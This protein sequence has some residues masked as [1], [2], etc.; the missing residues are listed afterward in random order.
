MASE[1]SEHLSDDD[2][3]MP[4]FGETSGRWVGVEQDGEA[5]GMA[6]ELE[7][8]R[9]PR[10]RG[11][12]PHVGEL[13]HFALLSQGGEVLELPHWAL[14]FTENQP[15]PFHPLRK[16]MKLAQKDAAAEEFARRMGQLV[17]GSG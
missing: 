6:G 8:F 4:D 16:T 1:H 3:R 10:L 9:P 12:Y 11:P 7:R 17:R 15:F 14:L 2:S 13:T 5:G